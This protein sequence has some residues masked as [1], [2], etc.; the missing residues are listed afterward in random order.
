MFI[1]AW[2]NDQSGQLAPSNIAIESELGRQ[3][4]GSLNVHHAG[5]VGLWEAR[6]TTITSPIMLA[7]GASISKLHTRT[8]A[9]PPLVLHAKLWLTGP[10][11]AKQL[12]QRIF[13]P[14]AYVTEAV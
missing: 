4:A 7:R 12:T 3:D 8:F 14:A 6:S 13:T 2:S 5:S 11:S 1:E 10:P 9:S